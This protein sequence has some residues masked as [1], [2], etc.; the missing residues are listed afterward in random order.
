LQGGRLLWPGA[1]YRR[2]SFTDSLS[3][4]ASLIGV[5][6][7]NSLSRNYFDLEVVTAQIGSSDGG[8]TMI[9]GGEVDG[10]YSPRKRRDGIPTAYFPHGLLRS[11]SDPEI[12]ADGAS[13]IHSLGGSSQNAERRRRTD[14][15][16]Q[17]VWKISPNVV[18][19]GPANEGGADD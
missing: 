14:C 8:I 7:V 16:E 6:N 3:L 10:Q 12:A 4:R 5:S 18:I 15:A 11:C 9:S 1:S 13:P 17:G 2:A 19:G